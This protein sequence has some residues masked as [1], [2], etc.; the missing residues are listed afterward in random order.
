ME[1]LLYLLLG[2]AAGVLAGLFGVGGGIIIVPVLVLSFTAQGIDPAVLTH[3]AVG[4][5][6]AVMSGYRFVLRAERAGKDTGLINLGPT[7]AD[8]KAS[9]RWRAPVADALAWLDSRL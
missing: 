1:F 8:P 9:W 5:S 6:L 2:A 3:L 4:T 7:R